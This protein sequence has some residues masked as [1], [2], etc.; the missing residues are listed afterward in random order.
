MERKDWEKV[1]PCDQGRP[2]RD[3]GFGWTY[4]CSRLCWQTLAFGDHLHDVCWCL[5]DT[6]L[7]LFSGDEASKG[8]NKGIYAKGGV[9]HGDVSL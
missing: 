5:D 4:T 3:I 1:R 2:C 8:R 6:E 7:E 9:H